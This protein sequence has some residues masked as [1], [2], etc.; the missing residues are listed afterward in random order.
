MSAALFLQRQTTDTSMNPCTVLQQTCVLALQG[1]AA[2]KR[3][4][5]LLAAGRETKNFG[6]QDTV[7]DQ[8]GEGIMATAHAQAAG[9]LG[10]SDVSSAEAA[11]AAWRQEQQRLL[12]NSATA[13]T[14]DPWSL[15]EGGP[16]STQEQLTR[17]ITHQQD[18]H[19][20]QLVDALHR[21]SASD[22]HP[23]A[24]QRLS[25]CFGEGSLVRVCLCLCMFG[26][27]RTVLCWSTCTHG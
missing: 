9:R 11:A 4:L 3:G 27:V 23:E 18:P 26:Y 13:V 17:A 1:H 24:A 15:P 6:G 14:H 8:V 5:T 19:Q 12:V 2:L 25:D 10:F 22:L 7:G 16:W 20:K 21:G